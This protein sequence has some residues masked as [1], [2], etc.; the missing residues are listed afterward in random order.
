MKSSLAIVTI[1]LFMAQSL[2]AHVGKDR[3]ELAISEMNPLL[4]LGADQVVREQDFRFEVTDIKSGRVYEKVVFT[5]LNEDARN[6]VFRLF[7]GPDSRIRN[8]SVTIYDKQG[9]FVRTSSRKDVQDYP[10]V[11]GGTLY[12]D[13]RFEQIELSYP[14]YP[15]TL[16]IEY[17]KDISGIEYVVYPDWQILP[18]FKTS[19]EQASYTVITDQPLHFRAYNIDLEPEITKESDATIYSWQVENM[20]TLSR[21]SY[22]PPAFQQYPMIL[23]SPG[24]FEIDGYTG[25]LESWKST[26]S[27]CIPYWR[28][29]MF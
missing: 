1:C 19:V 23:C 17:E 4:M 14:E 22:A 11:S 3:P 21:Q 27:S 18:D 13:S 12:Q 29:G 16:E 5:I 6:R 2:V 9:T 10:A 7:Y 20:P 28:A 26:A 25:S 24:T 8:N 15:Y